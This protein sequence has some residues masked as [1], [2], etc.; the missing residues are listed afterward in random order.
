MVDVHATL[1]DMI[2]S[3]ELPP[4]APLQQAE[5]ARKLNVSRTPMREAFRLLQEKG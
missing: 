4:G 5:M 1:R 3:G 2:I